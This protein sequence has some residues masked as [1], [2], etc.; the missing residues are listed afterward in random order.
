MCT[1]LVLVAAVSQ[2]A[3][4]PAR[5]EWYRH[6]VANAHFD[7]HS[8]PLGMGQGADALTEML[9]TMPVTMIQVS[10]QSNGPA[11]YPTEVGINNK[12]TGGYDTLGTFKEVTRR[13]G[14]KLCIYMSVDRRPLE[15]QAHPEWGQLDPSGKQV[16]SGDP[17][18]CQRPTRNRKGYLYERFLP[19]IREIIRKYD[20]DGVWFDGDYIL[21]RP[22]WCANCLKEWKADTGLDAPQNESSPEWG[23]WIAWHYARYCEYRRLVAEAIHQ[24]SPKAM[25][26]SNWSWAWSPEPVPDFVDTL[27]GDVWDIRTLQYTTMRW[28]AQQKTPWDMMSYTA[29]YRAFNREHSLQRSLQEAGL[30]IAA[31]GVWFIWGFSGG[32]IPPYGLEEAR[33]CAQF[34]RD[35]QRALGPT[36]SLSQVAILDSETSW[37][38]GGEAGVQSRVGCVARNLQE[39]HYFTD[40]ANEETLRRHLTPYQVIVVPDQRYLDPATVADLRKLATSGGTVIL[41]GAALMGDGHAE[42]DNAKALLSL[43]RLKPEGPPAAFDVGTSSYFISAVWKVEPTA[44]ETVVRLADGRPL[45]LRNRVG[46]GTVA[47]LATSSL[48]YPDDGF[49]ATMLRRLSKGP[50]YAVQGAGNAPIVCSLRGRKGEVILHATDLS[51]RSNGALVEVDSTGYTDPNPQLGNVAITLA[52]PEAPKQAYAVPTGTQA[53]LQHTGGLLTVT[54]DMLQTHA[55]VVLAAA[56]KP[57]FGFLPPETPL[58]EATPHPEDRRLGVLLSDDFEDTPAGGRP[59]PPWV[60]EIK[61]ATAI[62]ITDETAAVGK[63]SVRLTD[64]PDSSFWPFLHRSWA[65]IRRGKCQLSYD[66]RAEKGVACYM[67]LRYENRGAGPAIAVDGEGNVT[68]TGKPLMKVAPGA[69]MH[70]DVTFSLHVLNPSYDVSITLPGQ[71]PRTF[72]GLPYASEWFYLCDSLYF[73]GSGETAGSFYVDNVRFERLSAD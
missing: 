22:C 29:A 47:Y 37:A 2:A 62:A 54:I 21:T 5:S 36:M 31:G 46:S 11:T 50:S 72:T 9:G 39:G 52:L 51:T 14:R 61:D 53:R 66:L 28:G 68:A 58:P 42:T 25:Y 38:K 64:A 19:Q 43:T 56:A 45:L 10:A 17:I 1:A 3:P 40:I 26:T 13:L 69:W 18:V 15:L 4:R 23:R 70:V 20:P 63:H 60:S 71:A 59:G 67:E 44:A 49:M 7:N 33:H 48:T 73:V 30:T 27:S 57:P 41:T 35:R 6:S 55:A 65:S 34:A 32:P 12:E 16:I 8:G 24:S